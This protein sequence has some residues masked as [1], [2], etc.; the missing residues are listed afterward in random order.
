MDQMLE[1]RGWKLEVGRKL[2]AGVGARDGHSSVGT[3]SESREVTADQG[4][5]PASRS[6]AR[7]KLSL[8]PHPFQRPERGGSAALTT[9]A[10]P[11][12]VSSH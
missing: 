2:E 8:N 7:V 6:R 1:V 4:I 3:A 11:K 9:S 5:G 12:I 10:A